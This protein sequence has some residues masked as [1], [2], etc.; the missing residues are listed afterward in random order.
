MT[1]T[2][3]VWH[4]LAY[5]CCLGITPR[6]TSLISARPFRINGPDAIKPLNIA[7]T[8]PVDLIIRVSTDVKA[9]IKGVNITPPPTPATTDMIATKKLSKKEKKMLKKQKKVENMIS[10]F[11]RKICAFFM[12]S[13]IKVRLS[14][15]LKGFWERRR[16]S[17]Y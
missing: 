13:C 9:S 11:D 1:A 6:K 15:N 12:Y 17:V 10:I 8:S 3:Q 7:T 16:Q 4:L 2:H 5:H 14:L